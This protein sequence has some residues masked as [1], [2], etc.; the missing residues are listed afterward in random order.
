MRILVTGGAG[1]IG[2]AVR[3]R[4]A[5]DGHEVVATDVTD[6]GR[7][8]RDLVLLPLEDS[9]AIE[10]LA[11]R[12]RVEA[13]VHCGAIP[14]PMHAVGR[15]LDVV[16]VNVRASAALMDMARRL[17]M[18]RFVLCSS[19]SVY[20]DAG[21]RLIDEDMP[22]HPT[23]V[24]GASK[25]A[26]DALVDAFAAECGLDGVALRIARVYGPFRRGDCLIRQMADDALSGRRSVIAC[27][28]ALPYHYV[29]S[30]DVAG[31]VAA[32]LVPPTLPRRAYTVSGPG[33]AT[34]P[35]VVAAFRKV[36]PEAEI[37]LTPGT[38]PVS[39]MQREFDLS[40]IAEDLD[41]R[42]GYDLIRGTSDLVEAVRSGRAA[43]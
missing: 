32:S 15:P 34:M 18:R 12:G 27:D 21:D 17:D 43:A 4:L 13:V 24:Y 8:D 6:H 36:C 1:L 33:P 5:S 31:A 3:E 39:D 42:P 7:T 9:A 2:M 20:G 10:E 26:C 41:W 19:I 35:E 23:S 38:D 14:G 40:R 25:V 29:Y 30:A 37:D 16:D 28:P 11:R 22:L